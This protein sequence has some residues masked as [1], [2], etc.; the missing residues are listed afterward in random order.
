MKITLS[1]DINQ[2]NSLF[3]AFSQLDKHDV[4]T[5]GVEN[6]PKVVSV[7]YQIGGV[8]RRSIV[9]NM[10]ALRS[11][12]QSFEDARKQSFNELWP[13]KDMSELPLLSKDNPEKFKKFIS[14]VGKLVIEKDD[15]ELFTLFESVMY[16]KEELP[17][18]ALAV[19]DQHNLIIEDEKK[20]V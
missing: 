6:G 5:P 1:L 18:D 3:A 17:S 8:A 9:K 11:S 7:L 12:L 4:V 14:D 20:E 2:Q 13:E 19:L 15:V 10:N 16:G